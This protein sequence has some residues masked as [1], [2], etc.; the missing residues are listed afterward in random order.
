MSDPERIGKGDDLGA[1]LLAS[2]FSD[3]PP[4]G[5]RERTLVT[6]GAGAGV[7]LGAATT[8]KVASAAAK[9]AGT[10][11]WIKVAGGMIVTTTLATA[12]LV[13][14]T[15]NDAPAPA[16][17][18]AAAPPA[19]PP[20]AAP[21]GDR[22]VET[23][24]PTSIELAAPAKQATTPA[25]AVTRAPS[26]PA[27][28]ATGA[29]NASASESPLAK[30]LAAL[31]EARAALTGH[32]AARTLALLDR[33]ERAF[34]TGALRSEASVLRAEALLEGGDHKGAQALAR[35]LLARDPSG[36]HAK[37]L[38]TLANGAK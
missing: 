21:V 1:T 33:Y 29:D 5:A 35:T 19:K 26:A 22:A 34:P 3:A 11:L 38:T 15:P 37:R 10:A 18:R 16:L 28:A 30:E 25:R 31:D 32:D 23:P 7:A 2:A 9:T 14:L 12:T 24:L 6:L 4:A 36:P 8:T 20:Q 13:T 27:P 17:S